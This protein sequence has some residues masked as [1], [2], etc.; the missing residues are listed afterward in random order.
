MISMPEDKIFI[1]TSII[2]YTSEIHSKIEI[3]SRTQ[4]KGFRCQP[5]EDG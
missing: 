5:T 3:G 2:I 4:G 1:D